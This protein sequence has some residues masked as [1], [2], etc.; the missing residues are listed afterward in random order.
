MSCE[1]KKSKSPKGVVQS[2]LAAPLERKG[3][4]S[5]RETLRIHL[6]RVEGEAFT[7]GKKLRGQRLVFR[8]RKP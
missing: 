6:E 5:Y 2:G 3:D 7:N 1:G 8:G 4:F